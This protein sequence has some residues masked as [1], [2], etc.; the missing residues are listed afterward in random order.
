MIFCTKFGTPLNS[1]LY[2]QAIEKIIN[3]INLTRDP[4]DAMEKFSG[5]C[6]RHT[7]ATR[8]IALGFDPKTLQE[9]LGHSNIKI[10]LSLYV[11]PTEK[12]KTTCMNKLILK[13]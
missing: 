5:H 6:F 3:E 1:V 2:S 12:M 4:L 13:Q 7:F 11:H 8:C 10:T 9:I